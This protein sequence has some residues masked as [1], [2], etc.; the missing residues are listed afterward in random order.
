MHKIGQSGGFL[1]KPLR[2]FLKIGLPLLGNLFKYLNHYNA[3]DNILR[4]FDTLPNLLSTTSETKR[5]Y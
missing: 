3:G 4:L 2:P 1:G 5:G